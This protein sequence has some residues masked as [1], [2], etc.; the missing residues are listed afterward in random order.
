MKYST[1][2]IDLDDTLYINEDGLWAAIKERM[3][4][5]MIEKLDIPAEKVPD[6]REH[7][8]ATYGTTL[9]GLQHDFHVDADEYLR[10]VHD[11]PLDRYLKPDPELKELLLK[12][13]QKKWIFT[14][15]DSDHAIRVL[16]VLGV[17][18]AFEGIIDVRAM[19]FLCK[20]DI[21]VYRLAL[22]HAGNPA[23][24]NCVMFDDSEK[25]LRPAKE[26][27]MT[28]VLVNNLSENGSGVADYQIP[29]IKKIP[30]ILPE[31]FER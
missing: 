29:T 11:I 25:N 19:G 27:G 18:D 16:D 22:S 15:A 17:R 6:L 1:L 7:Y 28:T 12:I 10:Y 20:P 9:R 8:Y 13:P 2:F 3:S 23:P 21:Q 30:E 14:N 4:Q 26:L 5:Y 24:Q 31:I